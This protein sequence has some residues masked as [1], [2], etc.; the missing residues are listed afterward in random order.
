MWWSCEK[1]CQVRDTDLEIPTVKVNLKYSRQNSDDQ[2]TV[3]LK[4]S[5]EALCK[6][7]AASEKARLQ[8]RLSSSWAKELQ[9]QQAERTV[10][11]PKGKFSRDEEVS[12]VHSRA[13]SSGGA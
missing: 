13:G 11:S 12:Q 4:A 5:D 2:V 3:D 1:S 8:A 6:E 9:R 7:D 10:D